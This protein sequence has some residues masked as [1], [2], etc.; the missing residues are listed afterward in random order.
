MPGEDTHGEFTTG[1]FQRREILVQLRPFVAIA[2]DLRWA[3]EFMLEEV[4]E[5]EHCIRS[6]DTM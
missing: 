4:A 5:R 2:I 3:S 1:R 6:G